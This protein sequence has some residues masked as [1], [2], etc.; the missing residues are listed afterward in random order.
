MSQPGETFFTSVGC[1]DGRVQCPVSKYGKARYGVKYMDTITE[2][3]LV[4]QIIKEDAD[5]KLLESIKDKIMISIN[6]HHSKG[7]I[8]HGHQECAGNPVED[9]LHKENTVAA[10]KVIRE[11]V[12]NLD[13]EVHPVFVIKS[14]EEWEV[15][16]I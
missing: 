9:S 2:A 8:V 15:T 5:P 4:G 12:K 11:M 14:G 1:M 7:I 3:G 10:T 13:V 16:E 6:K